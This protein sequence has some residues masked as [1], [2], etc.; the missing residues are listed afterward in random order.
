MSKQG[1]VFSEI[2]FDSTFFASRFA[3]RYFAYLVTRHVPHYSVWTTRKHTSKSTHTSRDTRVET[4][5][6]K[7]YAYL[8]FGLTA[9]LRQRLVLLGAA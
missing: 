8:A 5:L 2:Y 9:P 3:I 1:P 7:A 6:N 4:L